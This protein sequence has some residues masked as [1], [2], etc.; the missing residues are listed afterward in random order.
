MFIFFK[1]LY[2]QSF[3]IDLEFNDS[4]FEVKEKICTQQ[5]FDLGNLRLI[6]AGK[7]LEDEK[8]IGDCG[9]RKKSTIHVVMRHSSG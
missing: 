1:T 9:V 2:G 8:L 3:E 4:I 7:E 5:G 6:F